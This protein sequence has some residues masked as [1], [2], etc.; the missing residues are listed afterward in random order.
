M[1]NKDVLSSRR[2]FLK[3]AGSRLAEVAIIGFVT[4]VWDACNP[5]PLLNMD[6]EADAGKTTTVDVSSLIADNAAIHSVTP[7]GKELLIV[8][9]AAGNFVPILLVCKH[10]GC[11]YPSIDLRGRTISCTCHGSQYDIF[12]HV[13]HGP[14]TTNLDTFRTIYNNAT[15]KLT[16]LF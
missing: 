3:V 8:R 10:Q 2:D 7:S 11:S 4:P 1:K 12:G 15:N 9:K 5:G 6:D 16:I 13:T 14:A